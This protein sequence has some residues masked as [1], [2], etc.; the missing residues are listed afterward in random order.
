MSISKPSADL[1]AGFKKVGDQMLGDW[2][3]KSGADGKAVVDAY[4]KM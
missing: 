3:K 2:L 1:T 4:K